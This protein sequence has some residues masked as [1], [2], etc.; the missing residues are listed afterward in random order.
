MGWFK[1]NLFF[2]VGGL[3][4][5]VLLGAAGFYDYKSWQRNNAAYAHLTELYDSKKN[6]TV[7]YKGKQI[8]PGESG[9]GKVDN[10]KLA[11]DEAA[12]LRQWLSQTTN[13]FRPITPIPNPAREQLNNQ[14][15]ANALHH[16]IVQL[17]QE[18][19]AA[20]VA[21]APD[22]NFSFTADQNLLTFAPGSLESLAVQLGEV[23]TISE[24]L[25]AAG[26]NALDGVQ[27]L[28][29]SADDSGA[30]ALATDY[31][32]DQPLTTEQGVLTPY[33]VTFRG[34]S[35]E[36]AR[37][38]GG[39]AASP[40]GFVVKAMS[41]QPSPSA[42]GVAATEA[43]QVAASAAAMANYY[44]MVGGGPMA[45]APVAGRGGLQTALNEQLLSV[46]LKIEVVKLAPKN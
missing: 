40:H 39:F 21:L 20:N 8:S 26:I 44:R 42:G 7:P 16:A 15:F 32:D 43:A 30:N 23:K 6:N 38:L 19:A 28:R 33:Q 11:R 37:V 24:I 35:P 12:Q 10:V 31:L 1:R 14:S 5:L 13:Y 3:V 17:Q 45:A 27:R 9:E 4:A 22:F 41:V 29:V 25:F 2:A 18:A 34:F 36:I 46:T